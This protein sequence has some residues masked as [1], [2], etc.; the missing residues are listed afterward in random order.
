MDPTE[1]SQS[2]QEQ[3]RRLKLDQLK[4]LGIDPYGGRVEGL[5]PL[6]QIRSQH[7]PE[8]GQDGGPTLKAAGRVMLKRDM[9]KLS[10]V[11]IRDETG[12]LQIAL[13]KRRVDDR[14]WEVR[15]LLDLGDQVVAEGK[16]GA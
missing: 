12:D 9:G 4:A 14:A 13:D 5:T 15:N 3:Q 16:L 11:T 2:D 8:F 7:R 6:D 1:P 10:F